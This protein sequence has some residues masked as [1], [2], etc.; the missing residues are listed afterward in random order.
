MQAEPS[1]S[2]RAMQALVSEAV[3]AK[4]NVTGISSD[5]LGGAVEAPLRSRMRFLHPSR[6]TVRPEPSRST[7]T[8]SS[9]WKVNL[10]W[11]W[12][13]LQATTIETLG[14]LLAHAQDHMRALC[15]DLYKLPGLV[16]VAWAVQD[17]E[18]IS[19]SPSRLFERNPGRL[20]GRVCWG[21]RTG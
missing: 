13:T 1:A 3:S 5:G 11:V 8:P 10:G 18:G 12:E 14:M 9:I 4:P 17:A 15:W 7:A 20:T 2:R 16:A 21:F 6:P 19:R